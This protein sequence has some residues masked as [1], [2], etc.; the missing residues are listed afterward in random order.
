MHKCS[1]LLLLIFTFCTATIYAQDDLEII[2]FE[3]GKKT[4]TSKNN[5]SNQLVIKSNPLSFLYGRQFFEAEYLL[6][7]YFTIEGGVGLTFAPLLTGYE[8]IYSEFYYNI[9]NDGNDC[10]SVNF[11]PQFD[12][13][14]QQLYSDF[15]IR[16]TNI[17]P[18]LSGALKFYVYNDAL[19]GPYISLNLKYY[20][21][22]YEVLT[23]EEDIDFIRST[24]NYQKETV[25]NLDYTVRLGSQTIYNP[26]IT[27]WFIGLGVR[28]INQ[29]RLDVGFDRGK[30]TWTNSSQSTKNSTFVVELGVR[31]GFFIA[32]K[33]PKSRSKKK[34]RRK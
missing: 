6:T 10:T 28:N 29:N 12:F 4:T 23:V 5:V 25:S 21:N 31:L 7:D 32:K 9:I 17:G 26:L 13:C 1:T 20:R 16:N 27:D 30:D 14:D 24:S 33:T 22:N 19:D 15:D 18:W 2:T 11:D 3:D 8:S 34:K